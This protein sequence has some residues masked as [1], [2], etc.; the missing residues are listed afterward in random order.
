MGLV[1]KKN[2]ARSAA[3][4]RDLPPDF[5]PLFS[6]PPACPRGN[7]AEAIVFGPLI[8]VPFSRG[9][10]L[11]PGLFGVGRAAGRAEQRLVPRPVERERHRLFHLKKD[12]VEKINKTNNGVRWG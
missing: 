8:A 4:G 1:P 9:S 12:K 2:E 10:L 5:S 3:L 6:P 11:V 7:N